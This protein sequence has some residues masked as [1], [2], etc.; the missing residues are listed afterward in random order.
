MIRLGRRDH[1]ARN[2]ELFDGGGHWGAGD[3]DDID[4]WM[5]PNISRPRC[6]FDFRPGGDLRSG[7]GGGK[8]LPS[9]SITGPHCSVRLDSCSTPRAGR[10]GG[11]GLKP[12][13]LSTTI[14]PSRTCSRTTTGDGAMRRDAWGARR[15]NV[16]SA[17]GR[18]SGLKSKDALSQLR[19]PII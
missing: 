15:S 9:R 19:R 10:S 8:G 3:G 18:D 5:P 4:H 11:G 13:P 17:T 1:G 14:S 2:G 16:G 6:I 12:T 7:D